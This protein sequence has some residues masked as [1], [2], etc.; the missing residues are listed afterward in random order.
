MPS[1]INAGRVSTSRY[2]LDQYPTSLS[3][4]PLHALLQ[5]NAVACRSPSAAGRSHASRYPPIFASAAREKIDPVL[6]VLA[7]C[8]DT[9]VV[10][11]RLPKRKFL[12]MSNSC[13][14]AW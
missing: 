13:D 5:C 11:A 6:E 8:D 3:A 1:A 12:A 10:I 7:L 2:G 14:E 4:T 9:Q